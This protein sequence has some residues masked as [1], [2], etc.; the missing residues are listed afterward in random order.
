MGIYVVFIFRTSL[1]I[2]SFQQGNE[3]NSDFRSVS[4]VIQ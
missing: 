1:L 3:E 2:L 4:E